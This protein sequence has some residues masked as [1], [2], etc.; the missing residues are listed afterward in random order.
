LIYVQSDG[1]RL[2]MRGKM[3]LVGDRT[4]SS[5]LTYTQPG[6]NGMPG[7]EIRI[8]VVDGA[9]TVTSV[10][11]AAAQGGNGVRVTDLKDVASR[12]EDLAE[13]ICATAAWVRNGS[14]AFRDFPL[15]AESRQSAMPSIRRARRKTRRKM[16]RE[17]LTRVADTY[18]AAERAPTEAVK[19]A[20]GVEHR[21]AGR[22]VAAA[23]E[24]GLLP[25][26]T[27]GKGGVD[28]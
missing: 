20:F 19:A 10:L 26:T 4:L 14:G 18:R 6:G 16:N 13:E 24:A 9:P 11:F 28:G 5:K 22:Y 17:L 23:R 12:L 27:R 7:L 2:E 3:V 15:S 25:P 8:E 21:T 1:A